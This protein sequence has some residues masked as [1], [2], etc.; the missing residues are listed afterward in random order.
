MGRFIVPS[1]NR[2]GCGVI[3]SC[4]LQ[5]MTQ[6]G[7]EVMS[8]YPHYDGEARYQRWC[9]CEERWR[10]GDL[11][12]AV[13]GALMKVHRE[14]GPGWDEQDYHLCFLDQLARVGIG[15]ESKVRGLLTHRGIEVD[16]FELDV[17]VDATL[18]VELKSIHQG[19][20]PAHYV[21]IINYLT[22]WRKTVGL[23][24]NFGQESLRLRRLQSPDTK[25]QIVL[26]TPPQCFSADDCQ[27][28]ADV[29]DALVDHNLHTY[30]LATLNK[31]LAVEARHQQLPCSKL[32]V[33][34]ACLERELPS[35]EVNAW[36]TG[37]HT[38]VHLSASPKGPAKQNRA[39]LRAYLK[40]SGI[41]QGILVNFE[42][43]KI[44][45]F[46]IF[47]PSQH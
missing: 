15:A 46:P 17:L 1:L 22:F 43:S 4:K 14:L 13:N 31:L 7:N 2:A 26:K 34:P 3:C 23:L 28:V 12:Y 21:Q 24:C 20:A 38:L 32:L 33:Q 16:R 39:V 6:I 40:Q 25:P 41:S 5:E 30:S 9:V 19:F 47:P 10:Y 44:T 45:I 37:D 18:I 42:P 11:S 35:R 29:L 36:R 27:A 8:D